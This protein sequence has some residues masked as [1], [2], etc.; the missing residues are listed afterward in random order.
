MV[1]IFL[2][3]KS[4]VT[5]FCE[6]IENIKTGSGGMPY[7]VQ[8]S[9]ISMFHLWLAEDTRVATKR[10]CFHRFGY[11]FKHTEDLYFHIKLDRIPDS[12]HWY[13]CSLK[14]QQK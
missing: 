2:F 5:D 3:L 10:C 13:S 6:N 4:T 9:L 14:F 7:P 11:G 12:Y 8:C 1:C